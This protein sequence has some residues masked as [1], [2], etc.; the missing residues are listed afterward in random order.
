MPIGIPRRKDRN[1][2]RKSLFHEPFET[3][4]MGGVRGSQ[5][6]VDNVHPAPDGPLERPKQR[7]RRRTQRAVEYLD[8]EVFGL[9]R[10]LLN[11][12]HHRGAVP[13]PIGECV[14]F[15]ASVRSH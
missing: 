9:R 5:A 1:A 15:D 14:L 13:Q 12:R 4:R 10:P 8:R 3:L 6:Q 11:R 7:L 2:G